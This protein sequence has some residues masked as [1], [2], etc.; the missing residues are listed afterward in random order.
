M[1][2]VQD[3][4]RVYDVTPIDSSDSTKSKLIASSTTRSGTAT[5][6]V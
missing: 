2:R 5:C 4:F 6:Q 3:E 1:R